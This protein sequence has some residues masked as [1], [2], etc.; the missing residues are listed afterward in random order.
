MDTKRIDVLVTKH[1]E[2][3]S[4]IQWFG[5]DI[6]KVVTSDKFGRI[7]ESVGRI[8]AIGEYDMNIDVSKPYNSEIKNIMYADMMGIEAYR[9]SAPPIAPANR[10]GI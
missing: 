6:V 8:T 3:R 10:E 9:E 1:P 5:G 7:S 2:D 4:D